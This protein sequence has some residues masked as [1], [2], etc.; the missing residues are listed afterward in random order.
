MGIMYCPMMKLVEG[1]V[2][3]QGHADEELDELLQ[4]PGHPDALRP[5]VADLVAQRRHEDEEEEVFR[6]DHRAGVRRVDQ[7]LQVL[8]SAGTTWSVTV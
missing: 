6:V 3:E 2:Q 4:Q 1:R 8:G 7:Q 5:R